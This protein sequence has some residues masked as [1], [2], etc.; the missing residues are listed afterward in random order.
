MGRLLAR[1]LPVRL[2]SAAVV[3][4]ALDPP[5]DQLRVV[6]DI[7]APRVVLPGSVQSTY[8]RGHLPGGWREYEVNTMRS[9][10][11]HRRDS[12]I[13]YLPPDEVQ[14]ESVGHILRRMLGRG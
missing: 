6:P 5:V 7:E 14:M 4:M 10:P 9:S 3:V 12:T 8:F 11:P 1:D 2:P 13:G